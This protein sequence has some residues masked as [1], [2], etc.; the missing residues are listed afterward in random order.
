MDVALEDDEILVLRVN[1]TFSSTLTSIY[2]EE[3]VIEG[4][5]YL[6]TQSL[7]FKGDEIIVKIDYRNCRDLLCSDS[8]TLLVEF[9]E[10]LSIPVL[11]WRGNLRYVSN[12][13]KASSPVNE[14]WKGRF[15]LVSPSESIKVNQI[16][17]SVKQDGSSV[18]RV[19]PDSL[20]PDM[21]N[22][23]SPGGRESSIP[24]VKIDGL[25]RINGYLLCHN[26]GFLFTNKVL[27]YRISV[28]YERIVFAFERVNGHEI[29]GLEIFYLEDG[30]ADNGLNL[31]FHSE[32]A[33][34][35]VSNLLSEWD[36]R[37]FSPQRVP[38]FLEEIRSF[39]QEGKLSNYHYLQM[40]N[41]IGGRSRSTLSYYPVFP[42]ILAE[43]SDLPVS[44]GKLEIRDLSK[45]V[46]ALRYERLE[47]LIQRM[48]HLPKQDQY[49]FG[50]HYSTP[51]FVAHWRIRDKPELHLKF[52]RGKIDHHSRLFHSI[53]DSWNAVLFGQT[54][55]M[56]LI[57]EFFEPNPTF[58]LR[59][60]PVNSSSGPLLDVELPKGCVC[61]Y[62]SDDL[63]GGVA[64]SWYPKVP[65]N[66][67][68]QEQLNA[69]WFLFVHR[70][71]LESGLVSKRLHLWID[72]IYGVKQSGQAA[73]EVFNVFH[74]ATYLTSKK[75]S[76]LVA[77]A[78]PQ[79]NAQSPIPSP[80]LLRQIA[81]FG[82]APLQLFHE[83]H[84]LRKITKS[85]IYLTAPRLTKDKLCSQFIAFL[86]NTN[87]AGPDSELLTSLSWVV[88]LLQNFPQVLPKRVLRTI[89]LNTGG[90]K[91]RIITRYSASDTLLS[92]NG[93][94]SAKF[95]NRTQSV[96]L[97]SKAECIVAHDN[98]IAILDESRLNIY[99]IKSL[100]FDP[101]ETK[102]HQ[103]NVT[104]GPSKGVMACTSNGDRILVATNQRDG[105]NVFN[106]A[107]TSALAYKTMIRSQNHRSLISCVAA[108]QECFHR[109]VTG[110]YDEAIGVWDLNAG[111]SIL[112]WHEGHKAP[113]Y[114]CAFSGNY[115]L[116]SAGDGSLIF[117]DIRQPHW[118][119]PIFQHQNSG[120]CL[121]PY[122]A[123]GHERIQFGESGYPGQ[124]LPLVMPTQSL[125]IQ[126]LW[127]QLHSMARQRHFLQV[128]EF[129]NASDLGHK[130]VYTYDLRRMDIP[131]ITFDLDP[132]TRA[133]NLE[134]SE[135]LLKAEKNL[136]LL[137][138]MATNQ[139]LS[140]WTLNSEQSIS[141][142]HVYPDLNLNKVISEP[143][144]PSYNDGDTNV[145]TRPFILVVSSPDDQ[146]SIVDQR[147]I[148]DLL[149]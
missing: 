91:D 35:G 111:P 36:F 62:G 71:V 26:L 79:S 75:G 49:L 61:P 63:P 38:S 57:P 33:R 39:W 90:S 65:L 116:S 128:S 109:C 88:N 83:N 95:L 7:L 132:G 119:V 85:G 47:S 84:P 143:L 69:A 60:L 137:V 53:P 103:F 52:N 105:L 123:I 147:I 59:N 15:R 19:G 54:S 92:W 96:S 86:T 46:G 117:K 34:A 146:R 11:K 81:E 66:E 136:V 23:F 149:Y 124:V 67:L 31:I 74:P 144:L 125:T 106:I 64:T 25:E 126:G 27:N 80:A 1:T 115:L 118:S 120:S 127:K 142:I 110:G 99:R 3:R 20:T 2:A 82:Q 113:I 9:T 108:N 141:E 21:W 122:L 139:E 4:D 134:G 138:N 112:N 145:E 13:Q 58:L 5:L 94:Q 87:P 130:M 100:F 40:L 104:V 42:W 131:S 24:C 45:P 12:F 10:V 133:I 41:C 89:G 107:E 28:L 70:C 32:E 129:P 68:S 50:S 140:R 55:F 135:C 8:G 14:P 148:L 44:P 37:L 22:L 17:L 18:T 16:L 78:I 97:A 93:I 102:P 101:E 6:S 77:S 76:N 30:G 121:Y 114:S 48:T 72:L 56:E 29:I 73:Q 43:Y 98:R 51:S